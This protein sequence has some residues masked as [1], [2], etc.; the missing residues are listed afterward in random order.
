MPYRWLQRVN[1]CKD[2]FLI[3]TDLQQ[4]V[5]FDPYRRA[6]LPSGMRSCLLQRAGCSFDDVLS[7]IRSWNVSPTGRTSVA[8]TLKTNPR[9]FPLHVRAL[10][11]REKYQRKF[12]ACFMCEHL[13][14]FLQMTLHTLH[15][16]SLVSSRLHSSTLQK[17]ERCSLSIK[18]H[19][20]FQAL[21]QQ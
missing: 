1:K 2:A 7:L 18:R 16:V 12:H 21:L 10:Y 15:P 20:E 4:N 13:K 11:A 9:V 14:L 8:L 5:I 6:P 17:S 19:E 3:F